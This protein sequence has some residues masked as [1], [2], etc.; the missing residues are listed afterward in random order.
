MPFEDQ[1]HLIMSP[2]VFWSSLKDSKIL[3]III[4]IPAIELIITTTIIIVI[5]I[6]TTTILTRTYKEV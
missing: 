3:I 2:H 1:Q 5:I 4:K 6:T